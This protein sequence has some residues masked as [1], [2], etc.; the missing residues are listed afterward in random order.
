MLPKMATVKHFNMNMGALE[1]TI[2][3]GAGP[4]RVYSVHLSALSSRER[5][6]QLDAML[7]VHR[8]A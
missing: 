2:E 6:I 5:M 8:R 4:I 3:T 7:D 1:G